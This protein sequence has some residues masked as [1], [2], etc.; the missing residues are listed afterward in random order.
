MLS[1]FPVSLPPGNTLSHPSS[2]WLFESVPSPTHSHLP[3]PDS[4][5]L[6]TKYLFS[7]WCLTRLS[8]AAYAGG[9]MSAPWL[10]AK[11][12]GALGPLV[13][14]YCSSYGVANDSIFYHPVLSPRLPFQII[15]HP[16]ICI[17]KKNEQKNQLRYVLKYWGMAWNQA[18]VVRGSDGREHKHMH[19]VLVPHR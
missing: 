19:L 4:C 13:G 16:W 12:P 10:I 5:T 11:Y 7:H 1:P 18:T 6:G 17:T 2:P 8:S 14:W 9:A 3:S 15:L